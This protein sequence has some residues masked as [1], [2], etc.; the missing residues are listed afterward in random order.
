[1]LRSASDQDF[2]QTWPILGSKNR[3]EV[4]W[5][6]KRSAPWGNWIFIDFSIRSQRGREPKNWKIYRFWAPKWIPKWSQNGDTVDLL[7]SPISRWRPGASQRASRTNFDL[8]FNGFSLIFGLILVYNFEDLQVVSF[9]TEGTEVAWELETRDLGF[10]F[11]V[12]P[13]AWELWALAPKWPKWSSKD[14]L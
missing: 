12:D 6:P 3:S 5:N 9:S 4:G 14:G 7:S 13:K 11:Q 8:I 10:A 2:D 1:M